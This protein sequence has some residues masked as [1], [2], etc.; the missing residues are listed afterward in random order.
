MRNSS[1]VDMCVVRKP[2]S[3]M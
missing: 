1:V 2:I 3:C